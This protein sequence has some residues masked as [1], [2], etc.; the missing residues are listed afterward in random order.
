MALPYLGMAIWPGVAARLPRPGSWMLHM[1]RM[2]GFLLIGTCLYLLSILPDT[3]VFPALILLLTIAFS[4]WIWGTWGELRAGG[5]R[6]F[7]LVVLCAAIPLCAAWTVFS[8]RSG[9][10]FVLF[11]SKLF[12]LQFR[13]ETLI[14]AFP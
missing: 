6:R 10:E 14:N 11:S 1:E 4:A 7:F 12:F 3:L 9:Q 2:L 13:R 8:P 5:A